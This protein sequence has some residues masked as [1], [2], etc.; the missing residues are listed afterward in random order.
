MTTVTQGD[1]ANCR[2]DFQSARY[3]LSIL[4]PLTLWTARVTNSATRGIYNITFDQGTGLD[5]AAVAPFQELWIGTTPG[6]REVGVVRIRSI[7]SGDSGV[8]GTVSVNWQGY[9]FGSGAYLTFIHN[10][11][12]AA[13]YPWLGLDDVLG[14]N[15]VFYKDV[16]D[17][18]TDENQADEIHPVGVINFSHRA[19]FIRNGEA[20]FWVDASPSYAM[21][22][23]ATITTYALSCYPTSGVTVNFNTTTGKG[24]VVVTSLTQEY[25]WLKL[26]V[27]DSNATSKVTY[28]AIFAHN[29]SPGSDTYPIVN[30]NVGSYSHDWDTGGVSAKIELDRTL[31]E[32]LS[33]DREAIDMIDEAF[34]ILWR[35]RTVGSSLIGHSHVNIV[36]S[37]S[38]T[39]VHPVMDLSY[40]TSATCDVRSTFKAG[41]LINGQIPANGTVIDMDFQVGASAPASTYGYV[42]SGI[43]TTYE[44]ILNVPLGDCDCE[45]YWKYGSDTIASQQLSPGLSQVKESVHPSNFLC[46]PSQ[47]LV[48]YLRDDNVEQDEPAGTG[49]MD[50]TLET[51]EA[52]LKNHFMFSIS[53]D[54]KESPSDWYE[55][56][57]YMTTARA[58][59]HI[60]EEH[61][62][63]LDVC[64]V[65][66]LNA[67]ED[68][69]PFAEFSGGT[70]YTMPDDILYQSGIRA[71]LIS[72]RNGQLKMCYDIQL[73]TDE[74]RALLPD[75]FKILKPDRGEEISIDEFEFNRVA[76]VYGDGVFWDGSFNSD[77]DVDVDRIGAYCALA[78]WYVP[79]WSGG[80]S[81]AQLSK[82][83][84]RSQLHLNEVVGRKYAQLNNPFPQISFAFRGD[85]LDVLAVGT[86]EFWK[87]D[88]LP[89]DNVKG[90]ILQNIRMI[91]RNID[92]DIDVTAG[93]IGVNTTWEPEVASLDAVTAVCPE[94]NIDIDG[95][96]PVDWEE[97][98]LPGTIVTSS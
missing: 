85:F 53:L 92:C 14:T 22:P 68:L 77:G 9:A 57:R 65:L 95:I 33:G 38:I 35:E 93:T 87:M 52:L 20:V 80:S 72:N 2:E 69:R 86:E 67:D 62:F 8:T 31:S 26:T 42:V 5:F 19:G 74:E 50:Y 1:L 34:T 89:Q 49:T 82:Q 12:I 73:L 79:H 47:L 58:A 46:F 97:P 54:A 6:G 29:P 96:P 81:T 13:K 43:L 24:Y 98:Y 32:I 66:D 18:Y 4:K 64:D 71:H 39:F 7:T 17:A 25:Y 15:E 63:F 40:S 90:L 30:F 91:L 59:H 28:R 84:V 56:H 11:P 16:F 88:V 60:L 61:S 75:V 44:M 23:G 41:I 45:V 70:L 37:S 76:L 48:G 55:L 94:I 21:A 10:Y 3:Y 83:T 51:P 78:P 36:R 27:T